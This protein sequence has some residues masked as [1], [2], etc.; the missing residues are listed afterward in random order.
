MKPPAGIY[1][2]V[3]FCA[4]KC[5]YC[6]FYSGRYTREAAERYTAAVIRN[7][8][9]LP[10]HLDADT[11]YFGGGTPSLMPETML[12]DILGALRK[13]CNLTED[14]ETTLEVNPL[15]VTAEKLRA[16]KS[17]G[18]NR[19]SMGIQSFQPEILRIL[20]R[21]HTPEKGI[22]AVMLAHDA[23]FRN[24]SIDLM[25]GP[26]Q[27]TESVWQADLETAAALP[28][29][30]ISAYLLKIE[31]GT[32]FGSD[33]PDLL[34]D[35]VSADRWMQMHDV[36][37]ASGFRHY[38]IS[39]FAKPGSESRHNCKYWKLHPYYGIGPAAHS[40]HDGKRFAVPRD[41]DAFCAAAQQPYEIT[42]PH[43]ETDAE[44]IMLGLRLAEGI[45]L[46]DVPDCRARLLKNAEQLIPELLCSDG[47]RLHMTPEG[48]LV[49]NS[50]LVRLLSGL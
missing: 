33:P 28:V 6:D 39:N 45:A 47:S 10:E 42:E 22:A 8:A 24:I 31:P 50:V 34:D 20:G 11:V 5:P 44:R 12:A 32:P 15:T 7:I 21:R 13:H 1:I 25:L 41:L 43:A 19:L 38:E 49:S 9:A 40:C 16:W 30:H 14:T 35:D 3:P 48:W 46:A 37:T 27:Q 26:E 4:Q 29:K 18:I 36:L 23:G 17:I 2:H